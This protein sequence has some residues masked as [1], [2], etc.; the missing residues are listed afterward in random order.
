MNTG[1]N[2]ENENINYNNT[3]DNTISDENITTDYNNSETNNINFMSEDYNQ[4]YDNNVNNPFYKCKIEQLNYDTDDEQDYNYL[5]LFILWNFE[6]NYDFFNLNTLR[7]FINKNEE[8]Y[9]LLN[10]LKSYRNNTE[11]IVTG[12][13]LKLDNI[14]FKYLDQIHLY[15]IIYYDNVKCNIEFYGI[16]NQEIDEDIIINNIGNESKYGK[17]GNFI[18]NLN[19]NSTN[20]YDF[21]LLHQLIKIE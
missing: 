18:K 13:L 7:C 2:S 16:F 19:I 15:I 14:K 12:I 11:S 5:R 4:L 3:S 20:N 10:N 1:D 17:N 21:L 9:K 8:F 6:Y